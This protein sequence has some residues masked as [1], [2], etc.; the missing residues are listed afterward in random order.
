MSL[1][2]HEITAFLNAYYESIGIT[3]M[4]FWNFWSESAES[5][6]TEL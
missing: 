1:C 4:L 6:L 5:I 2:D 3:K